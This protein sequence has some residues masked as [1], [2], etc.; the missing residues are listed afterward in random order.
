VKPCTGMRKKRGHTLRP[1]CISRTTATWNTA[2]RWSVRLLWSQALAQDSDKRFPEDT[3][4]RFTYLPTLK[5]QWALSRGDASAALNEL[6]TGEPY[7]L[8]VSGSGSGSYGTFSAIYLR[9][10]AYLMAHRST[11]AAAEFQKIS[12]QL[13]LIPL[14]PVHVMARL[15]LARALRMAGE[16]AK[17]KAA[18][19]DFL[20][21]WKSADPGIPILREAQAESASLQ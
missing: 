8:A 10:R 18:Y 12:D 7:E 4:V 16:N 3:Y 2:P 14:D 11:E 13:G 20:E 17:A 21:R 1:P 9:G 6:Q 5:A 19:Q 15:Q